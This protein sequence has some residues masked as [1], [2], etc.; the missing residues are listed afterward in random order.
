MT[1]P[2]TKIYVRYLDT[3][4]WGACFV[5]RNASW[6]SVLLSRAAG[7]PPACGPTGFS[8]LRGTKPRVAPNPARN[9]PSDARCAEQ[10]FI[11]T[12][13]LRHRSGYFMPYG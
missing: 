13:T 4:E 8:L 9:T 1:I 10:Q 12:R 6:K 7:R 11:L 5:K 3:Y 2:A